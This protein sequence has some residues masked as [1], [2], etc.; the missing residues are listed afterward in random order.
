MTLEPWSAPLTISLMETL[1]LVGVTKKMGLPLLS[2][3]DQGMWSP[4]LFIPSISELK[5]LIYW[6]ERLRSQVAP[7][8]HPTL[9]H[10]ADLPQVGQDEHMCPQ[11]PCPGSLVEQRFQARRG[12]SRRPEATTPAQCLE[13]ELRNFA[14]EAKDISE[15][16]HNGTEFIWKRTWGSLNLGCSPK[17]ERFDGKQIRGGW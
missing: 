16:L 2:A 12:K 1:L 13:K 17:Y 9:T 11:F 5:R 15:V 10:W 7:F 3:S 6:W 14:Q 8:I 4:A